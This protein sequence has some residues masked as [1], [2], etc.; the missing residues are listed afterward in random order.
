MAH[1][2]LHNMVFMIEISI[3]VNNV[4]KMSLIKID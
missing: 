4:Q 1:T 2:R 3:I